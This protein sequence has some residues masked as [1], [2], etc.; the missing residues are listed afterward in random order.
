MCLACVNKEI[1]NEH[2][3]LYISDYLHKFIPYF[4]QIH[5]ELI[6]LL[7]DSLVPRSY[8][9]GDTIISKGDHGDF[10]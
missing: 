5:I 7:A 1:K 4:S 8:N 9:K 3:R 10:M 6:T 2:E